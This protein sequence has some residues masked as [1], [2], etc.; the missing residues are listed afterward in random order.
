M[1][2]LI[3]V[4]NKMIGLGDILSGIIIKILKEKNISDIVDLGS[5]AGGSMPDVFNTLKEKHG[6]QDVTLTM[7]DLFPNQDALKRF[8]NNGDQSISYHKQSVDATQLATAPKGLK[9][10]VNCFHHMPPASARKILQ[11]AA[12][13][14]EPI[15]IYEMGENKIPLFIWWLFLP[16]SLVILMVMVWFMTPFVRPLTWKQLLFTYLIPIIPVFYAWDGQ[17]SLPRI[18]TL[19][20][21]DELLEGLDQEGYVWEK[22]HGKNSKGKNQGTYV[23]GLPA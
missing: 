2:N 17:A 7:T 14:K 20:D 3:V 13:N 4:F 9:T 11:S 8:N 16:L 1:T 19:E 6:L 12:E 10:M 21:M 5:G 18:Y 22:G 23:L 15:L